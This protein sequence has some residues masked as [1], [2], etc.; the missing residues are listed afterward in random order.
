LR[1]KANLNIVL[2]QDNDPAPAKR[3]IVPSAK[4]GHIPSVESPAACR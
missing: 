2:A 4:K 1:G 3:K